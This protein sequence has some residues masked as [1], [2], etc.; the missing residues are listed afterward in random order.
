M[1]TQCLMNLKITWLL[2]V[3]DVTRLSSREK[4]ASASY[5]CTWSPASW[6][7]WVVIPLWWGSVRTGRG[8]VGMHWRDNWRGDGRGVRK[9][10]Q[11]H[12]IADCV[13][14]TRDWTDRKRAV[15]VFIVPPSPLSVVRSIETFCPPRWSLF[16]VFPILLCV[17]R[18][19]S[20]SLWTDFGN[21]TSSKPS[22][23]VT[24]SFI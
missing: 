21:H 17:D 1:K 9:V 4:L 24:I 5:F 13:P 7:R 20:T 12:L 3:H 10:A 16:C 8:E 23:T 19:P 2:R 11:N 14:S 18:I 6:A 15:C 22:P